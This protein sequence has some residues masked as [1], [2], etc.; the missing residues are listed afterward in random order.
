MF[1]AVCDTVV[2]AN[3][4][5]CRSQSPSSANRSQEEVKVHHPIR[6]GTMV[7]KVEVGLIRGVLELEYMQRLVVSVH[8]QAEDGHL[9]ITT[10]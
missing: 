5:Q 3:M 7:V 9:A 10:P 1:C 6:V 8:E 2:G 4:T